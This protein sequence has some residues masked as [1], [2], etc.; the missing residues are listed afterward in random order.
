MQRVLVP[1]AQGF[2]ELEAVTVIDLL[3]R[4]GVVVIT[5]G[6]EQGLVRSARGVQISPDMSLDMAL[7]QSFDMIILP[8]GQPGATHLAADQRVAATLKSM[9]ADGKR[10]AAICAA[11]AVLAAC[12]LLRNKK[13]TCFP[14][15]LDSYVQA[16]HIQ[17]TS[18]AVQVDGLITTS[19]G[20]GTAMD[21]ALELIRQLLGESQAR[22]V[23]HQLMRV[24]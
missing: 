11:P 22:T 6:L 21:F 18:S 2:E 4:A 15:A 14:G 20:P 16:Q 5:A 19:R 13:A 24:A 7:R 8:G 1:L 9:L 10:V 3:R 17:L 12:E 23:E